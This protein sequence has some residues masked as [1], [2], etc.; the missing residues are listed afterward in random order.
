MA[1]KLNDDLSKLSE[2]LCANKLKLNV[3]KSKFMNLRSN[4]RNTTETPKIIIKGSELEMVKSIKYL[5]II[6]DEKL[7]FNEKLRKRDFWKNSQ[8]FSAWCYIHIRIHKCFM[9]Q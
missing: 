2:W 9:N 4:R 7:N 6:I 1:T 8:E 5:G 3:D